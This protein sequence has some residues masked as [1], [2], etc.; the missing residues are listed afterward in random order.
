MSMFAA[1]R[2]TGRPRTWQLRVRW[3]LRRLALDCQSC[4]RCHCCIGSCSAV[5]LPPTHARD[6]GGCGKGRELRNRTKNAKACKQHHLHYTP[7]VDRESTGTPQVR[8]PSVCSSKETPEV[9]VAVSPE[10]ARLFSCERC[11]LDAA[12]DT[13]C[14]SLPE[15]STTPQLSRPSAAA[16]PPPTLQTPSASSKPRRRHRSRSSTSEK[17]PPG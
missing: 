1:S 2:R 6:A 9:C 14:C 3:H 5:F 15:K 7:R 11:V 13:D 17:T 16:P 10:Q 8:C 12:T 4:R